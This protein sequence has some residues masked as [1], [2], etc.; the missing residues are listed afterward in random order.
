M[1]NYKETPDWDTAVLDLTEKR[2]V[3]HVVEV[4]GAGTIQKSM[5]AVKMGGHIARYRRAFRRQRR[6]QPGFDFDEIGQAA[7]NFRRLAA[8]VRTDE[9]DALPAQSYEAGD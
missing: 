6:N 5:K 2:G 1:I 3:D 4:G 9:S 8:D 7:R